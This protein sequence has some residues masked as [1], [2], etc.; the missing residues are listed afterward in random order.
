[1]HLDGQLQFSLGQASFAGVKPD[2]EDSIGIRVPEGNLLTT[3]GACAVIA[4]GVSAAEAGKE[5]SHTCVTNFLSDYFST[6]D[7]WTVKKSAHQVLIALNRWLYGQGQRFL[8]AEKGYVSTFSIAV[9]KSQTAHLFHVGDSRIYR[10]RNGDLEQLTRDHATRINKTQSYLTRAMGLD[11]RLDVDYRTVDM[12]VGDVF[13]LTTDGVHDFLRAADLRSMLIEAMNEA[14]S[15]VTRLPYKPADYEA[16]CHQIIAAALENQSGDNLSCQIVRIDK[17][18]LENSSDVYRKL[19]ALPFPPHLTPGMILD[20]YRIEREIHASNRSQ[21]YLVRQ[22]ETRKCYAMKTPSVNFEDD[23]AYIERF[24]MESW[25]GSRI[26]SPHIVDVVESDSRKSCLYY[27]TEYIEGV[28]VSRW[29][30]QQAATDIGSRIAIVEQ[31]IKGV[32]ALHRRET[33]H[34]DLRPDNILVDKND[35]VS[36]IDFGACYVAGIAEIATPIE[37][38]K[39]LGTAN[40]SAPEP[41]LG[42]KPSVQSDL[43]SIAVVTFEMLAGQQ[44][45][46]G[47][48]ES[49]RSLQA[50]SSLKYVPC[51]HYNPH[52]PVWMD[53]A[54]KKALS[55]S[56]EL[57]YQDISEFLYDLQ[58]PNADFLSSEALPFIQRNPLRFWQGLS[59]LLLMS[60]IITLLWLI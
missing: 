49:C 4:D 3:K 53:G 13:L 27:L 47:K 20:G 46:Q 32:R 37:R 33:L 31:I 8:S 36:I 26:D 60:Q 11:M 51:Y 56:P 22:T 18:P 19:T 55:I 52:V 50:Y 38:D 15:S 25:I 1:M 12:E 10:L 5:A 29:A 28:S 45:Y 7:T 48:L 59:A 39:I 42:R 16:L 14:E 35:H 57:R 6:P 23:A 9:F 21:L 24:V 58:H 54:L 30:E 44:P 34:Q 41:M 17:L 2:N 40:Y 43:F